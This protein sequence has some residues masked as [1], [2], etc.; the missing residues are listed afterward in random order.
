VAEA[1]RVRGVPFVLASAYGRPDL[2]AD[3]LAAAPN[4]GKPTAEG[5]LL[6]ALGKAVRP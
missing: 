6:A 2:G 4:M 1:L 3:V 5:R